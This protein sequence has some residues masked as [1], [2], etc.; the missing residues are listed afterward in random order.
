LALDWAYEFLEARTSIVVFRGACVLEAIA[1]DAGEVRTIADIG[2]DGH[3]FEDIPTVSSAS[4]RGD[5]SRGAEKYSAFNWEAGMD[6]PTC[7]TT[8]SSTSAI[9]WPAT[10]AN[11]ATCPMPPELSGA[12]H[13]FVLWPELNAG[14]LRV[15]GAS[16]R[17]RSL[18][19]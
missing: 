7:S 8:E 10:R 9:T 16:R 6:V 15:P 18:R 4:H 17:L 19:T 3:G 11:L 12:I 13:S 14:K 1:A 5:L 2:A